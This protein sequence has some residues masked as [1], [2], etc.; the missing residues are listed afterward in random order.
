M[1]VLRILLVMLLVCGAA[2]AAPPAQAEREIEGLIAGLASS[3]CEFERNGTWYGAAEA[4]AHLRSKYE[5]L[6]KRGLADS[7]EQFIERGASESS[8]SGENYKVR[9]PDKP[10]TESGIWFRALLTRQRAQPDDAPPR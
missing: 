4:E 9:C 8:I 2:M 10:V 3:G 6:R 5:W 7:A 1:P